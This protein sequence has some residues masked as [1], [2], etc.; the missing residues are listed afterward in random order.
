[1]SEEPLFKNARIVLED[2][3]LEGSLSVSQG[4]IA[5]LGNGPSRLPGGLDFEGDYLL[6]GLI[7]LH[8][9]NLEKHFSPRPGVRWPALPA[10]LGHD[11]QV[12]AA[13]ITT[14]YDAVSLGDVSD[15]SARRAYLESMVQSV[16]AAVERGA[17][18]AEHRLHLRCEVSD[19]QC[20]DYCRAC[21]DNPLVGLVSVMDHTG[22]Q[23]QFASMEVYRAFYKKQHRLDDAQFD[24]LHQ[25]R[26]TAH[27]EFSGPNRRAV[28]AL[29]RER[30]HPLASH[31]DA[32]L[33]HIAEA[34]ADGVVIAEFPT[35]QAAARAAREAGLAVLMGAPNLILGGSHTGN[36]AALD[37]A[38]GGLLDILS[39][40]YVPGALIEAAFRL[41]REVGIALPAALATV[42]ANPARAIGLADRGRIAPGLAADLVRVREIDGLP[43]VRGVW[44][45]GERVI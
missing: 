3:I 26:L 10:V 28:V 6:P 13:G 29:S 40:D 42:T 24:A 37:F 4:R 36:A 11:A 44:R 45:R 5:D 27:K 25:R 12:A 17:L 32:T 23:R 18:R 30:G 15:G 22:G 31:D 33:E 20:L 7:E 8:T 34:A 1:M 16:S 43:V 19:P 2:G 9:D 41:C 39:S 21:I 38:R 14:V 35:T